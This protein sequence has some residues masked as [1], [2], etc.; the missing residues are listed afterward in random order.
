M[1]KPEAQRLVLGLGLGLGVAITSCSMILVGDKDYVDLDATGSSSGETT[2]GT[3]TTAG[4]TATGT[5]GAA[6]SA[7]SAGAGG[8][9][10]GQGGSTG[11]CGSGQGGCGGAGSSTASSTSTATSTAS[12][13]ASSSSSSSTGSGGTPPCGPGG[14]LS[15]SFTGA[16]LDLAKWGMYSD[17]AGSTVA[18]TS[19]QIA[20]FSTGADKAFAG[21]YSKQR[22]PLQACSVSLKLP[23]SPKLAGMTAFFLLSSKMGDPYQVDFAQNGNY[24]NMEVKLPNGIT[25]ASNQIPFVKGTHVYW[26]FRH[27]SASGG[28]VHWETSNT[29]VTWVEQ[30]KYSSASLG[31]PI[32]QMLANFGVT[33]TGSLSATVHMDSFNLIP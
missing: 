10:T 32:D 23:D 24:L 4:E 17:G 1:K 30:F 22:F 5:G 27:S 31:F 12:S 9:T 13:S 21:V 25:K 6:M 2:T 15:D 19:N 18:Q 28:T 8:M 11:T 20:I 7:S 26:R 16:T 29:G 14:P 3:V 33:S